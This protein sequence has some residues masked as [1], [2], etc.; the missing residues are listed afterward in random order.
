MIVQIIF[1]GAIFL[2]TGIGIYL[3][4]IVHLRTEA[5]VSHRRKAWIILIYKL[6]EGGTPEDV[7]RRF[8]SYG[9]FKEQ[10]WDLRKWMFWG[11]YPDLK[12]GEMKNLH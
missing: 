11:F 5:I 12:D 8:D 7:F 3:I 4:Y 9:S 6:Q 10:F 1:L 2:M